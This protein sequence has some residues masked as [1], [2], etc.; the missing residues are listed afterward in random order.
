VAFWL[1]WWY[2]DI[3]NAQGCYLSSDHRFKRRISIAFDRIWLA[4]LITNNFD[5][6]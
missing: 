5:T 3:T 4:V 2:L 6:G 1:W